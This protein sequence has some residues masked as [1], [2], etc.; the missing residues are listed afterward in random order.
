[1]VVKIEGA[2]IKSS[3]RIPLKNP[4]EALHNPLSKQ[5]NEQRFAWLVRDD[6]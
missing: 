5:A 3:L 2:A 1:M 6:F 4:L